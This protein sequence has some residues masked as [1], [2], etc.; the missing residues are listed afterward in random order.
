M[1]S[2]KDSSKFS[3]SKDGVSAADEQ[4]S[5]DNSDD[6]LSDDVV[7]DIEEEA[8]E[9]SNNTA[10]SETSEI[11]DAPELPIEEV[12]EPVTGVALEI[13]TDPVIESTENPVVEEQPAPEVKG[14]ADDAEVDEVIDDIMVEEELDIDE[15]DEQSTKHSAGKTKNPESEISLFI[16]KLWRNPKSRWG[17]LG[18]AT[19]LMLA[20]ALIPTTRYFIL[21]TAQ[22][23]STIELTVLDSS[24]L[25]PLKNVKVTAA[26]ASAQTDSAGVARLQKVR[27]GETTLRIEK[28]A[29]ASQDRTITVGWGSNPLG[30]YQ[31]TPVGSQYTF[32]IRDAFSGKPI[33]KAEATSGEGNASSDEDGK[34]VLALDTAELDD[35]AQVS[36]AITA[37][38]YRNETINITVNNKETQ[39]IEM[40]PARKHTFVSKR[41]GK[42][43]V[44]TVDVDGKNER[45][46][47]G[48]SGYERDD[49]ALVPHPS[50]NFAAYV[51]TRENTRNQSGYLLSTLYILDTDNGDLVRID[52]SEQIQ[53]VGWSRSGRLIYVK[54]AAGASGTDPKRHRLM[55]FNNEDHSDTKELAG[56]NSFNDVMMAND[57]VYYAPSNVFQEVNAAMYVSDP[58]GSNIQTILDKEVYSIIR[59]SYDTL[60]F[61]GDNDK[62][63]EFVIGSPLAAE[64]S[65]PASQTNHMYL[66]NQD[67]TFSLWVDDRDGKGVLIAR[68][69]DQGEEKMLVE[70]GGLKM[71]LYWLNKNYIVYRVA[72]GVETADYVMNIQGGEPRKIIDTT[73]TAGI[74][75]WYYY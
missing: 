23:R 41:S 35:S 40:V 45:R 62:W 11:P 24:T 71:P 51:A 68:D 50:K 42:Y 67:K 60:Y 56:S 55:S 69:N 25:Q 13:E 37:A 18:G 74:S 7:N 12:V 29:F 49:I 57:R 48:G 70:R 31:V 9:V 15:P 30:E 21:N 20:L 27:L 19:A 8:A 65:P 58:D 63:Y 22:V 53:V 73:D 1:S 33:A 14:E 10:L 59:S 6:I 38:D 32:L 54:I 61:A 39:S 64:T 4:I 2:S 5:F 52:Q 26:N 3:D 66:D 44:Y 46:I 17:I 72:D 34:L 16:R 75:R 47:V 36:V 43:D 28:R